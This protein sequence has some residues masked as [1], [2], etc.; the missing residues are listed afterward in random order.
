MIDPALRMVAE[1][2]PG[3]AGP[4]PGAFD[5]VVGAKTCLYTM[6][7]DE[8]FILDQHPFMENVWIAAGFSGH[9]FKF[10][11]AIG[12]TLAELALSGMATLLLASSG[13]SGRFPQPYKDC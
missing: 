9:G 2:L 10:A 11:P 12:E 1:L 6:T 3:L 7:P 5:R 13:L 8:H 4:L